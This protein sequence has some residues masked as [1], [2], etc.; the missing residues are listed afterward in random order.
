MQRADTLDRLL[1]L[2]AL[3]FFGLVCLFIVKRRILDRGL[4]V[5]GVIGKLVPRRA[6][7]A[8]R[9]VKEAITGIVASVTSLMGSAPSLTASHIATQKSGTIVLPPAPTQLASP[10]S[11]D[12]VLSSILP[13]GVYDEPEGAEDSYVW[14]TE[15]PVDLVKSGRPIVVHNEL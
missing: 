4:R 3:F 6:I 1:I 11:L 8:E 10:S 12:R 9:E 2:A 15:E 7:G 14:P 13:P 5:F